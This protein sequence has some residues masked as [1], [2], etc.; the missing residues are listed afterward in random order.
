MEETT[1]DDSLRLRSGSRDCWL[2]GVEAKADGH[3]WILLAQN[4]PAPDS[5]NFCRATGAIALA[6]KERGWDMGASPDL[7]A[8]VG[9]RPQASTVIGSTGALASSC[10]TVV[11]S[12]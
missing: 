2:S 11:D 7:Q 12:R 3:I 8:S 10:V 6:V 4:L 9:D 1:R 5:R